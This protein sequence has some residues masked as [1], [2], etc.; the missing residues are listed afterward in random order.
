MQGYLCDVLCL[1]FSLVY[2]TKQTNKQTHTSNWGFRFSL[3]VE[4]LFLLSVLFLFKYRVW[5][6][7]G[8]WG[9]GCVPMGAE[10]TKSRIKCEIPWIWIYR[11]L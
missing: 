8:V 9:C 3:I 5:M 1:R 10:P 4:A 2:S 6:W 11:Q 7:L